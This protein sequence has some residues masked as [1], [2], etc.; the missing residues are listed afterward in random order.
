QHIS[1]FYT[2][3]DLEHKR[4][5]EL[6]RI[7][8]EEGRVEDEGWRVRSDGTRFWADV[9]ITALYDDDGVLKG[10]GKV[11]SD[12]T[13]RKRAEQERGELSERLQ[14][15][16]DEERRRIAA[17]LHD[18]TSPLLTSLVNKLYTLRERTRKEPEVEK[19]LDETLT[20]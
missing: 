4:P 14:R 7:A 8:R 5:E 18:T 10:F 1:R 12:L 6:L 13:E 2:P 17:E 20:V 11:T 9:V 3:E 19:A 15:F 16:Q